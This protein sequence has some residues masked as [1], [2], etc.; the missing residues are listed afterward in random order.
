MSEIKKQNVML[1]L[2][3]IVDLDSVKQFLKVFVGR[4]CP[5]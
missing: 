3:Q 5:P 2:S 1:Y 4:P